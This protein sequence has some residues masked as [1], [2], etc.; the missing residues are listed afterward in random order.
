MEGLFYI[1][2]GIAL[3]GIMIILAIGYE[4][5]FFG[6]I[7]CLLWPITCPIYYIIKRKYEEKEEDE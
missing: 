4:Y 6:I 2:L 3:A 1:W 7:F 5:K